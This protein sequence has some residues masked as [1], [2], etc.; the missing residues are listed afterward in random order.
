MSQFSTQLIGRAWNL[1]I[2]GTYAQTELGHGTFIRGLETQV[3]ESRKADAKAGGEGVILSRAKM[4]YLCC[5]LFLV[6]LFFA[7]IITYLCCGLFL[8]CL[9][10]ACEDN[11]S[12]LWSFFDVSSSRVKITYLCC[13]LSFVCLFLTREDNISLLR[14]FSPV[15]FPRLE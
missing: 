8:V 10:F 1:E 5:G 4:T 9:F 3:R 6:C 12:W 15:S 13:G 14:Y 2:V 7:A 11:I